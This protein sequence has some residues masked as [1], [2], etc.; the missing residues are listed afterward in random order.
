MVSITFAMLKKIDNDLQRPEIFQ[1]CLKKVSGNSV[2]L[3]QDFEHSS[4]NIQHVLH[5]KKRG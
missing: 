3:I 2:S 4:A 5:S 1:A